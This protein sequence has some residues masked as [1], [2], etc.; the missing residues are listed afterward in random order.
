MRHISAEASRGNHTYPLVLTKGPSHP[1]CNSRSSPT[2]PSPLERKHESPAHIQRSPIS[3]SY[4]ERRDPFPVWS[5]KKCQRSRRVSRGGAL[6]WKGERDTRALPAFQES[7]R[8]LSTFQGNL[9]SLHC[10]DFQSEIDSHHGGPWESPVGEIC[11]KAS[12]ESLE[13]KPQIT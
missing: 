7:P 11:G 9:F 6:N 12:W 13:G 1:C 10:L 4:I 2:Y 8:C 3:S 5:R